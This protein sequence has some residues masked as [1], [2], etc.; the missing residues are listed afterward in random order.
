MHGRNCLHGKGFG[1][2][3]SVQLERLECLEPH[4]RRP[5]PARGAWMRQHQ[6]SGKCHLP[7]L[8]VEVVRMLVM[9]DQDH[10]D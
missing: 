5:E 4:S 2:I 10:I 7:P 9:A 8:S 3:G 1:A 6:R